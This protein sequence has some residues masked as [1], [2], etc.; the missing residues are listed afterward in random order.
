MKQEVKKH[1]RVKL[2]Y[3]LRRIWVQEKNKPLSREVAKKTSSKILRDLSETM[4]E[5]NE[6]LET[7]DEETSSM[8]RRENTWVQ[9]KEITWEH[10]KGITTKLH[11]GLPRKYRRR[12]LKESYGRNA[13]KARLFLDVLKIAYSSFSATFST[14]N[15]FP[16]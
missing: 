1:I 16:Y 15:I 2:I 3:N 14:R 13:K 10:C 6:T 7:H 8:A 4:L 9:A 12:K 11:C 5:S